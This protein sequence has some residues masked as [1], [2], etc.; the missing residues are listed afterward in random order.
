MRVRT[1]YC[2]IIVK[3][4][5]QYVMSSIHSLITL[6]FIHSIRNVWFW[7]FSVSKCQLQ[8]VCHRATVPICVYFLVSPQPFVWVCVMGYRILV[9]IY[10]RTEIKRMHGHSEIDVKM[11]KRQNE[12]QWKQIFTHR[13][14]S[15]WYHQHRRPQS[16]NHWPSLDRWPVPTHILIQDVC[17]LCWIHAPNVMCRPTRKMQCDLNENTDKNGI[18]NLAARAINDALTLVRQCDECDLYKIAGTI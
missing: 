12:K 18:N 3:P 11:K 16:N 10:F 17:R 7:Y 15:L 2:D 6:Y 1:G 8:P 4:N 5:R 9:S 13:D 14:D